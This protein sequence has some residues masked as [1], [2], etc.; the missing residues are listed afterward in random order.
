M[1]KFNSLLIGFAT[2]SICASLSAEELADESRLLAKYDVNGDSV[3]SVNEIEDKRKRVFEAMDENV[4][5]GVSFDE[6]ENLDQRR[7]EMILKAR[8]QKLDL[9]ADGILSAAEYSTYLG[10][11]DRMDQNGDGR[12]SEREIKKLTS[13]EGKEKSKLKAKNADACLLW[14]CVRKK[15]W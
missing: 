14:V 7:R 13:D 4:D 9:D 6:Y 10:S 12:V 8:F 5:G 2:L 3:I 11:F 1:N 15:A